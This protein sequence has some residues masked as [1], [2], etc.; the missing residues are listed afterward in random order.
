[1]LIGVCFSTLRN[2]SAVSFFSAVSGGGDVD[3]RL[4]LHWD[5]FR[6]KMLDKSVVIKMRL[7][8]I[9]KSSPDP[10]SPHE[11]SVLLSV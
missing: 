7:M 5:Y 6:L 4:S 1:M 10:L 2:P 11:V 8:Q 9:R 3:C